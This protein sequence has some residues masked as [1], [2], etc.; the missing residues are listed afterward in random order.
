MRAYFAAWGDRNAYASAHL[1]W[2][3]NPDARWAA[4]TI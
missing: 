2:G 3:M 1:G 4:L